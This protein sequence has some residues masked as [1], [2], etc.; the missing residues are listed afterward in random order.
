M[1]IFR[2]LDYGEFTNYGL[3]RKQ[4]RQFVGKIEM[5]FFED[6][7]QDNLI[8]V[9]LL[10]RDARFNATFSGTFNRVDDKN[11]FKAKEK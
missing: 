4:L 11:R 10:T 5:D 8:R 7:D 1:Y 2:V 3:V 9:H 6:L